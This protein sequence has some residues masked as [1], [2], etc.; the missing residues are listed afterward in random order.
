MVTGSIPWRCVT[1]SAFYVLTNDSPKESNREW[2]DNKI[3]SS[4][5][6]C[7]R[8]L[9]IW[10][11]SNHSRAYCFANHSCC[12]LDSLVLPVQHRSIQPVSRQTTSFPDIVSQSKS[13][14]VSSRHSYL[15]SLCEEEAI[16]WCSSALPC[17]DYGFD[18]IY[19]VGVVRWGLEIGKVG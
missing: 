4:W 14:M 1:P 19:W 2:K 10:S 15:L 8:I 7:K 6:V 13:A 16:L 17:Y 11:P 5:L 9:R 18:Q 12:Y 3:C